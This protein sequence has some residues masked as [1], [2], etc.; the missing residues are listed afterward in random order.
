MSI[1]LPETTTFNSDLMHLANTLKIPSFRHVKM[2]DE[3][4][5]KP[6]N[7]ECGII[8]LE[9]HTQQ[10]SHWTCYFKDGNR[11]YYFDSYGQAPPTEI[12]TYLKTPRELKQDA[13][14]IQRSA[15]MVQHIDTDECGSLCLYVL[16]KLSIGEPF[17]KILATL[18]HRFYESPNAPLDIKV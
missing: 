16:K 11:R 5:G 8:N 3:I 6:H 13:P 17:S 12:L 4:Y 2:R 10:G 7:R 14:V 15:V 9:R 1:I 18:Q